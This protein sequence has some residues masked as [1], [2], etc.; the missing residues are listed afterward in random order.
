[1]STQPIKTAEFFEVVQQ[2]AEVCR[3]YAEQ[4]RKASLGIVP[5]P[6]P[7]QQPQQRSLLRCPQ[8]GDEMERR[9]GSKGEFWGCVN[10]PGCRGTLDPRVVAKM[11]ARSASIENRSDD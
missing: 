8:C 11:R 5:A 2:F 4:C 3:A 9:N 6:K 1:M 7:R 10:Y